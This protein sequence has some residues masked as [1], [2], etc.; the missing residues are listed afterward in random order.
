MRRSSGVI[1]RRDRVS[2]LKRHAF[3]PNEIDAH[4]RSHADW[5]EFVRRR[6]AEIV[7][8]SL[9][10]ESFPEA[11]EIGAGNGRQSRTIARFCT[12][13]VCTEFDESSYSYLG[14]KFRQQ[15][16][17]SVEYRI[18][19]AQ[20]L[21]Q[22][23]DESFDLVFS[24][25][26]LEHIPDIDKCLAECNRVLKVDGIMIHTMPS[27][28]LKAVGGFVDLL[29][30]RFPPVHGVSRNHI[31]EFGEFGVERWKSKFERNGLIVDEIVGLPFYIGHGNSGM[32][33]IKMGNRLRLSASYAFFVIKGTAG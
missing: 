7:F 8:S 4:K 13:L 21:S 29:K 1:S 28:L 5:H 12:H 18:C 30:L 19:D 14:E 25:N 10:R 23:S 27:R 26:V 11:L 31:E 33:I 3:T 22:F 16:L 32:P 17:E 24:S 20:D 9:E 6:E 2:D 15:E